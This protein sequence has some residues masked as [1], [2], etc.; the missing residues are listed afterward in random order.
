MRTSKCL[1]KHLNMNMSCWGRK[2]KEMWLNCRRH[3]KRTLRNLD[4]HQTWKIC[5]YLMTRISQFMSNPPISLIST[6][7]F[8]IRTLDSIWNHLSP[9]LPIINNNSSPRQKQFKLQEKRRLILTMPIKIRLVISKGKW[10][11]LDSSWRSLTWEIAS[12]VWRKGT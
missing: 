7:Q 10:L 4:L 6:L 11:S 5:R 3:L 8:L 1:L 2:M 12:L 9:Q